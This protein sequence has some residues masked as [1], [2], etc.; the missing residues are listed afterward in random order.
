MTYVFHFDDHPKVHLITEA[1]PGPRWNGFEAPCP[2][3]KELVRFLD[4]LRPE[5]TDEGEWWEVL[6]PLVT[7]YGVNQPGWDEPI[8]GV[9]GFVWQETRMF[10]SVDSPMNRA[11]AQGHLN[12]KGHALVAYYTPMDVQETIF[13]MVRLCCPEEGSTNG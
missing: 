6:E 4:K 3:P 2:T 12:R 1:R 7:Y 8:T 9:N 11:E 10:H 13:T 5:F